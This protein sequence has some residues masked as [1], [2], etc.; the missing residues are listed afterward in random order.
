MKRRTRHEDIQSGD[1]IFGLAE[2]GQEKILLVTAVHDGR[3]ETRHITTQTRVTFL[4]DGTSL[5]A[6]DG[7]TCRIASVAPLSPEQHAA[8]LSLDHK[9]RTT[10]RSD[11][12]RLTDPEKRLLRDAVPYFT[13]HPLPE[14]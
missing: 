7:G 6:W 2:G 8:A 10:T 4:P 12:F 9:I 13:A 14:S 3:I 5:P 1:I 11:D